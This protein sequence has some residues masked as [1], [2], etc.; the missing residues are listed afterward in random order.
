MEPYPKWDLTHFH[1]FICYINKSKLKFI[2]EWSY[3]LALVI[4]HRYRALYFRLVEFKMLEKSYA[5]IEHSLTDEV[6][7]TLNKQKYNRPFCL[8]FYIFKENLHLPQI[9]GL[10]VT[11]LRY[12][13]NILKQQWKTVEVYYAFIRYLTLWTFNF[14]E[15][16]YHVN[17][18]HFSNIQ[19]KNKLNSKL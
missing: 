11:S 9:F 5:N 16:I 10:F 3:L 12:S 6:G 19:V 18:T 2:I 13:Y 17:L 7:N 1:D 14:R 15:I 8:L 4:Y